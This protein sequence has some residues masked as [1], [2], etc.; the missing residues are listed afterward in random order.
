MTGRKIGLAISSIVLPRLG[1]ILFAAVFVAVLGIGPKMMNVDGDLGRHITLGNYI[2]ESRTIPT[3][4]IFSSTK[5]GDPLTPHEWLAEVIF[6]LAHKVAGLDGVVWL[7]ALVLAGSLWVVY[8]YSLELSNMSLVALAGGILAAAAGSLHWLTRPHIFTIL[9]TA[10]WTMQLDRLRLGVRK[11]WAV[12]P[13]IML[14]W[15]NLHG[16]YIAGFVIWAAFM[17]GMMLERQL[18]RNQLRSFMLV[19]LTSFLV[20]FINPAG[21]GIWQTGIGFLG[22]QY[23]VS[24]TAEYLPPDFQNP[25]FWPFLGV[26]LLSLLLLGNSKTRLPWVYNLQLSGWTAL[27]LFSGRNIPL[28]LV[29][30]IPI[31]SQSCSRILIAAKGSRFANWLV[32][33]QSRIDASEEQIKGGGVAVITAATTLVMLLSGHRL[34]FQHTGNRFSPDVFPEKAVTWLEEN[35]PEGAGFNYFPWGGYL[36]YRLWPDKLVFIDGQTDFYGE[37][38]TREYEKVITLQ[39]GWPVILNRYRVEWILMPEASPL[40]SFLDESDGWRLVYQDQTANLFYRVPE[41]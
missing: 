16:G 38:L 24:H 26:L 4:D 2:I 27:A 11:N 10:L 21:Y 40:S 19:G 29:V 41:N 17:L 15:V 20:S 6:A 13:V 9:F 22:N 31:L 14:V 12:F 7:T 36:L 35:P 8:R 33:F 23:L 39:P 37:E 25:V 30:A 32:A 34:D 5:Y 1:E 3:Q 18:A 28:Y